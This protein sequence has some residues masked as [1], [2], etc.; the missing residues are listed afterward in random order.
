MDTDFYCSQCEYRDKCELCDQI[1]FCEDCAQ[2]DE[3]TV[4][5]VYCEAGHEIEC[6]ND[7]TL[8]SDV[9]EQEEFEDEEY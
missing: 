5:N 2:Y 3:C 4:R 1:N 6:N 9:E 8:K 7:F